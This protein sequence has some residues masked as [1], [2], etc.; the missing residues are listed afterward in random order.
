MKSHVAFS[1]IVLAALLVSS[2]SGVNSLSADNV[3]LSMPILAANGIISD[4]S[5]ANSVMPKVILFAGS[6]RLEAEVA[7]TP[8]QAAAGL[9]YRNSL[10]PDQAMLF[11]YPMPHKVVFQM[12]HT[13]IPISAAFI[14]SFGTI[15]EI[16]DLEPVSAVPVSSKSGAVRFVL[17]VNRGWFTNNGVGTG[18]RI[19]TVRMPRQ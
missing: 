6:G 19:M 14:D 8:E 3:N 10:A 18:S 16:Y 9:S 5:P 11:T 17:E 2:C 7:N 13:L 12:R 4:A 1:A 15:M